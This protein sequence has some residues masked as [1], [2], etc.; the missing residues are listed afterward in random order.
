MSNV[1]KMTGLVLVVGAV[2]LVSQL[3][4]TSAQV[5]V[6]PT[7]S[8]AP[9]QVLDGRFRVDLTFA[10]SSVRVDEVRRI[11]FHENYFVLFTLNQSGRIVPLN[12][13]VKLHWEPA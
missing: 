4:S 11:E 8:K 6:Q 10:D 3:T 13:L 9:T 5:Q 7:E 1:A 12:G 2:L